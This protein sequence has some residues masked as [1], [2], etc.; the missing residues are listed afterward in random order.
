MAFLRLPGVGMVIEPE[1]R[2]K[3]GWRMVNRIDAASRGMPLGYATFPSDSSRPPAGIEVAVA[4]SNL[5]MFIGQTARAGTEQA[6]E[7]GVHSAARARRA[8]MSFR[9]DCMTG[10]RFVAILTVH[11]LG[12]RRGP[13]YGTLVHSQL[14]PLPA[15]EASAMHPL[16]ALLFILPL[17]C[18]PPC[19][20]PWTGSSRS[21]TTRFRRS[22]RGLRRD[23]GFA[24]LVEYG[25]KRI[26]FDTGD[27]GAER[28]CARAARGFTPAGLRGRVA[29]AWRS[30]RRARV[31][32]HD[33]SRRHDLRAEGKTSAPRGRDPERVQC[34]RTP[35]CR[36]GC[37][38]AG[39][40]HRRPCLLHSV[41][42]RRHSSPRLRRAWRSSRPCPAR[43]ARS[44]CVSCRWRSARPRA[45]TGRRVL[46]PRH[47]DDPRGTQPFDQ[48]R[49]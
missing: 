26:L 35:R 23:W 9:D 20:A 28:Q 22:A 13:A 30:H 10:N 7:G 3:T 25:G 45:S 34:D 15:L 41:A 5:A 27:D 36:L 4:G 6:A 21:C 38:N 47:R 11:W 42:Q 48:R 29:P 37:G 12:R 1:Q 46:A 33:Q 31:L 40:L 39:A 24:A 16:A 2:R 17:P 49:A 19:P 44:R 8:R 18:M 32:A 14:P 43:R